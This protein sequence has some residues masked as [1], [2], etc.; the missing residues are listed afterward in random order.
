MMIRRK[1]LYIR[2]DHF[3]RL[4]EF[5]DAVRHANVMLLLNSPSDGE[6]LKGWLEV[7]DQILSSYHPAPWK[8]E[9]VY[10]PPTEDEDHHL[11]V[12]DILN[13]SLEEDTLR[14]AE[15]VLLTNLVEVVEEVAG[16]LRTIEKVF[17][18]AE[19][20]LDGLTPVHREALR[21]RFVHTIVATMK[22]AHDA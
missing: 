14:S 22:E 15:L 19:F 5:R 18:F 6:Y 8:Q 16:S 7:A 11:S 4:R 21:S 20:M 9:T 17:A 2:D 13:D 3:V 10:L 12:Q 1:T